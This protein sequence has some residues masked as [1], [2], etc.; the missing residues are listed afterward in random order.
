MHRRPLPYEWSLVSRLQRALV[1]CTFTVALVLRLAT[2]ARLPQGSIPGAQP[3]SLSVSS[4]PLVSTEKV[5]LSPGQRLPP[6][7]PELRLPFCA[8][9]S[10]LRWQA[11]RGVS[12]TSSG[13]DMQT[14]KH[15]HDKTTLNSL[16]HNVET[17]NEWTSQD[18]ET[19]EGYGQEGVHVE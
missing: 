16:R 17:V 10:R 14:T 3:P 11:H 4:I 15:C 7:G 2:S 13:A 19:C 1:F 6:V 9:H 18:R 5:G 8:L 12:L